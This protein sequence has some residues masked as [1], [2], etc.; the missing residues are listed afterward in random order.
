MQIE[1]NNP[2]GPRKINY[3]PDSEGTKYNFSCHIRYFPRPDPIPQDVKNHCDGLPVKRRC[4][5]LTLRQVSSDRRLDGTAEA[6]GVPEEI[7][8][9]VH[10]ILKTDVDRPFRTALKPVLDV[11]MNRDL[12]AGIQANLFPRG[13]V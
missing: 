11:R 13:I 2:F 9:F 10:Q 3:R 5:S 12:F 8:G 7:P 1:E 4:C 6:V